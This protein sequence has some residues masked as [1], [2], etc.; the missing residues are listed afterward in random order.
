MEIVL[1]LICVWSYLAFARFRRT[2]RRFGEDGGRTDVAIRPFQVDPDEPGGRSKLAQTEENFGPGAG[3]A[4]ARISAL[5]EAEH[6]PLDYSRAIT[7]NTFEAHRLVAAA[8]RR[9]LAEP[10]VERLFRAHFAEGLHIGDP[11]VLDAIADELGVTRHGASTDELRAELRS[12][13]DQGVTGVPRFRFG[14]RPALTGAL[15]EDTLYDALTREHALTGT[16]PR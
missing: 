3:E 10:M 15:S 16:R 8:A 1:D 9:G 7:A 6:L 11:T 2:H 12:V 5:A 4:L 14:D 13:R